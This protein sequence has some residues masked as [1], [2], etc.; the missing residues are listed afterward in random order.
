MQKRT[1]PLAEK[2]GLD[3]VS[4]LAQLSVEPVDRARVERAAAL[5]GHARL[6]GPVEVVGLF[7]SVEKF[8]TELNPDF[9]SK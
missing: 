7:A 5:V 2:S 9:S 1:S 3:S 6:Q 8:G 4:D